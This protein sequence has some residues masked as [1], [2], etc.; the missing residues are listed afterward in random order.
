MAPGSLRSLRGPR[1]TRVR[2]VR[3]RYWGGGYTGGA[4]CGGGAAG[5]IASREIAARE[6][7]SLK[8][9]AWPRAR[10][11]RSGGHAGPFAV[12]GRGTGAVGTRAL[13]VSQRGTGAL[14]TRVAPPTRTVTFPWDFGATFHGL[15]DCDQVWSQLGVARCVVRCRHLKRSALSRSDPPPRSLCHVNLPNNPQAPLQ[16]KRSLA[17]RS[18]APEPL[19]RH[20]AQQPPSAPPSEA[21]SREAIFCLGAPAT[22]PRPTPPKRPSKRSALSRSDLLSP[23]HRRSA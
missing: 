16:A 17:Q 6:S 15:A 11:A 2:R 10:C 22:S 7:A 4:W 23:H 3:A 13:A 8:S 20:A 18:S 9:P 19:P 1:R 14:G 21:L 5:G 12:S